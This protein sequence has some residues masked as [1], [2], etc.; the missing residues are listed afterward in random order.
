MEDLK[1]QQLMEMGFS[2]EK[3]VEALQKANNDSALAVAYLF[4][5][6]I[7]EIETPPLESIAGTSE[8]TPSSS[9]NPILTYQDTVQISNPEDIP[10]FY[11]QKP[12]PDY[13]PPEYEFDVNANHTGHD[14]RVRRTYGQEN[15]NPI[16]VNNS[17]DQF[18]NYDGRYSNHSYQTTEYHKNCSSSESSIE[19][20]QCIFN[21][22]QTYTRE[23]HLPQVILPK[24]AYMVKNYIAPL[25]IMFSQ[26]NSFNKYVF[27]TK[28]EYKNDELPYNPFWFKANTDITV[29]QTELDEDTYK[30]NVEL[31]RTIA[32]LSDISKRS[33]ISSSNLIQRFLPNLNLNTDNLSEQI[34]EIIKQLYM[35]ISKI[36]P[37]FDNLFKSIVESVSEE[38]QNDIYFILI[39]LESR[40]ANIYESLNSLFWVDEENLGNIRFASIAPILTFQLLLDDESYQAKPFTL[41]EEF[42]PEIYSLKY[43]ELIVD[44]YNR[45]LQIQQQRS[46]LS[47]EIMQLNTHG[48]KLIRNFLKNSINHLKKENKLEAATDLTNLQER[49]IDLRYSKTEEL[50]LL[51]TKYSNLNIFNYENLLNYIEQSDLP[52]PNK[53]LLIGVIVSDCEFFFRS[54]K[55][56]SIDID[57]EWYYVT[58][59]P[60]PGSDGSIID[61]SIETMTTDSV[62]LF[63]YDHSDLKHLVLIYG[64]DGFDSKD[65]DFEVPQPLRKFFDQD[66]DE[67]EKILKE[68]EC[69]IIVDSDDNDSDDDKEI[70]NIEIEN[71]ELENTE[72][73]NI[74]IEK[75]KNQNETTEKEQTPNQNQD[76]NLIDP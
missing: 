6:P 35:T 57:E 30:F 62:K 45:R 14:N 44:L 5:E 21:L 37:N 46:S 33:F 40:G 10:T 28:I 68:I 50:N 56:A 11:P 20:E 60:Q 3:A 52:K 1:I 63:V 67:L 34:E 7:D 29:P 66:N 19:D 26:L 18:N 13:M 27:E 55:L 15:R 24:R 31:Q 58:A 12:L 69:Q 53:Y 70:E 65:S 42:Y 38:F 54:K 32:F 72:F 61:Y 73:E 74:E 76:I 25:L 47:N 23:D 36:N 22:K 59:I 75:H 41:H 4:N 51:N 2:R 43:S 48:G 16:A 17:N 64:K 9:D 71:E 8:D 39:D 49:L